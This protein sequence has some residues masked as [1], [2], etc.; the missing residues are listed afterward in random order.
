M[1][2]LIDF[3]LRHGY[4]LLFA[5]VAAEQIG[6]PIPAVPPLMAMGA[7]IGRGRFD[8]TST[9]VLAAVAATLSDLLW[10]Q[11]GRKRGGSVLA[12]VCRLSLEPDSCVRLTRSS[13]ARYGPRSLLLSKFIPGF[14]TAAPP[15]AGLSRISMW[16]FLLWD[17]G[18]SVVWAG[19]YLLIGL[20][21]SEELE[22]AA[23]G[24]LRF[25]S[26]ALLAMAAGLAIYI[27]YKYYQRRRFLNDMRV[28]RITP[29]ELKRRMDAGE[30]LMIVDLRLTQELEEGKVTLPGALRMSP[31]ELESRHDEIPRGREIVLYCS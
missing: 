23:E 14:S 19:S 16:R 3:L 12:L 13:F 7:L 24:A 20:L 26:W 28:A 17:F 25:G 29:G 30:D 4:L 1:H 5:F 8:F 2:S 18:G 15:L 9:L 21:F 6:L 22:R 31:D 11:L 27:G 10:Y